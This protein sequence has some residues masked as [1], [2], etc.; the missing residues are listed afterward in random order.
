M[1]N[2]PFQRPP[3]GQRPTREEREAASGKVKVKGSTLKMNPKKGLKSA[4]GS[5]RYLDEDSYVAL[6]EKVARRDNFVCFASRF[7]P[8]HNCIEPFDAA[9]LVAQRDLG[10]NHPALDDPAICLYACRLAHTQLDNWQGPFVNVAARDRIRF[11][12]GTE[13][14]DAVWKYDL[15]VLADRFFGGAA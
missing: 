7:D 4:G 6:L 2:T 3:V 8:A 11:I 14:E 9:H 1:T 13:F 15:A 12:A 10:H 5:N